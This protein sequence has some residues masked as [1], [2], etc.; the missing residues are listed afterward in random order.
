MIQELITYF[1]L[2]ATVVIALHKTVL[3]F[4]AGTSA[5]DNCSGS[6]SGCQLAGLKNKIDHIKIENSHLQQ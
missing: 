6:K 3:F 5:C 4:R 2:I 1:I